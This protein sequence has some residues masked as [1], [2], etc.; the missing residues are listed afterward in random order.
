MRRF[1]VLIVVALA[2]F[3][4]MPG[5]ASPGYAVNSPIQHIIVLMQENHSFAS[6]LGNFCNQ[7]NAGVTSRANGCVSGLPDSVTLADGVTVAPS[8]TPDTVPSI[9]H[10]VKAQQLAMANKW[11]QIT[12]CSSYQCISYYPASS[13]PNLSALAVNYTV[14]DHA[15]TL[16]DSPS[17]G[18]HLN[19]FAATT[20]G[21]T[22]DNPFPNK[23]LPA[24]NRDWGCDSN[25]EARFLPINGTYIPP[26]PSCI[27][28]FSLGLPYGGAYGPTVAKNV[29]TILQRM[30]AASVSWNIYA[31]KP[32]DSGGAFWSGC[33]SFAS[34]LD[35]PEFS[36]VYES[37]QYF[38]DAAAGNLPNVSFVMPEGKNGSQF[39]GAFS[40]H[41]KQS[42]SAG[43]NW[44][45]RIVSAAMT[46]P[47]ASST[48]IIIT[49]DDC[50]CFYDSVNPPI[51]PDGRQMGFRAPF[52]IVSQYAKAG[53]TDSTVTSNTGSIL[54]FI[55]WNF[56]LTSLNANDASADNLSS[57]FNFAQAAIKFPV[58][59]YQHIASWKL[60]LN[61]SVAS[62]GT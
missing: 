1:F 61:P 45:G 44:I 29:P 21:F 38:T 15:F 35:T 10:S 24:G 26:Q 60:K 20:D 30:D 43:D 52:V 46:G 14:L 13:V 31:A 56:N 9:D 62:D 58:M 18:G 6:E 5:N 51:A 48:A 16:A 8:I 11:D 7:V 4:V 40:Q 32:T 19:E 34:C 28:D 39:D 50:G 57:D 12:G 49:Y 33:P 36:H 27:P 2:F 42:N 53:Y 23:S 17:W 59:R 54:A 22:G 37:G 41:N 47:E 25:M 3:L 55:E